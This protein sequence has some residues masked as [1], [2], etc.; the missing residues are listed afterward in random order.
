MAATGI[1]FMTFPDVT[2]NL[3]TVLSVFPPSNA[4]H[5]TLYRIFGTEV[6]LTAC[7][8]Y[9]AFTM[10]YEGASPEE[11]KKDAW[12]ETRDQA[13]E[14]KFG[15]HVGTSQ[16]TVGERFTS[17]VKNV[18]NSPEKQFKNYAKFDSSPKSDTGFAPFA[19][20]YITTPNTLLRLQHVTAYLTINS[21]D[22]PYLF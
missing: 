6:F 16:Q 2:K 17:V 11:R 8:T 15:Q 4:S 21:T 12:K 22:T 9:I 7:L 13:L 10:A 20:G 18:K 14:K 3:D 19:I 5:E 1:I